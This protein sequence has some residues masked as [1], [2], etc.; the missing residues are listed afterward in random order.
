MILIVRSVPSFWNRFVFWDF[1]IYDYK[2]PISRSTPVIVRF[3]CN[4][5]I[6]YK[7]LHS[8]IFQPKELIFRPKSAAQ[9]TEQQSI[10]QRKNLLSVFLGLFTIAVLRIWNVPSL[11]APLRSAPSRSLTLHSVPSRSTLLWDKFRP[12]T[13]SKGDRAICMT[14][15]FKRRFSLQFRQFAWQ[16]LCTRK[17]STLLASPYDDEFNN[18]T[19][20]LANL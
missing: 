13:N 12:M 14:T 1:I 7:I 18:C 16:K 9:S 5:S 15:T 17:R 2:Y 8:G 3:L 11:S 20:L 19:S 10:L 4:E 6:S